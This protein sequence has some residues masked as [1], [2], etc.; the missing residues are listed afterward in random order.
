V[1][2]GFLDGPLFVRLQAVML[3]V[4]QVTATLLLWVLNP[5]AQAQT[6]TFALFLSVD[7]MGFVILSYL[8]R[9]HRYGRAP[10]PAWLAVGYFVLV[11][12]LAFD[13]I[14]V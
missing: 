9:S 2:R 12:L 13:L 8:Y 11:A 10:S 4:L 5:I 14:L 3:I 1:S 7:L 6:D